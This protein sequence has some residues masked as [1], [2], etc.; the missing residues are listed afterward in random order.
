[1]RRRWVG[2]IG[3]MGGLLAALGALGALLGCDAQ[4]QAQ[5]QAG[6]S[7]EADVRAAFGPPEAEYTEPDGSRVL[8]YPRQPEG[9]TNLMVVLSPT[10]S[11][12]ETRQ[13]LQPASF[14]LIEPGQSQDQ[15]LRT[16]GRPGKRQT[17]ALKQQTEW[18][19]YWLDGQTEMEFTVVF[20]AS[21]RV[22]SSVS[23][24]DMRERLR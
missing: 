4:R 9:R 20:D 13:V 21:G 24:P 8:A 15:V 16:L 19:W 1:M 7:T 10:G 22:L 2:A 6:V 12:R 17:Y 5:L 11:Y 23:R 18:D 14:R 3:M